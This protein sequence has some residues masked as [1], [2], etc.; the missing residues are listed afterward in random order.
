[1]SEAGTTLFISD[2]QTSTA[3]E[4]ALW[5][6]NGEGAGGLQGSNCR[7]HC[8]TVVGCDQNSHC[9]KNGHALTTARHTFVKGEMLVT[10]PGISGIVAATFSGVDASRHFQPEN[11]NNLW[12]TTLPN[13]LKENGALTMYRVFQ[14]KEP[15]ES[16][17]ETI[18]KAKSKVQYYLRKKERDG[19][20]CHFFRI[21]R[22]L[23]YLYS[24]KTVQI[25]YL[26]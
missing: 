23:F 21:R 22:L 7:S 24:G 8:K 6:C 4:R 25:V 9:Q 26:G 11:D 16:D 14:L 5:R 13:E 2:A 15:V 3:P 20:E 17:E 10:P 1:M 19:K 18:L 12:T